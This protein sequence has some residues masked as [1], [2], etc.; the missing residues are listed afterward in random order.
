MS[1]I[2]NFRSSP[3]LSQPSHSSP[4]N[5]LQSPLPHRSSSHPRLSHS[6]LTSLFSLLPHKRASTILPPRPTPHFTTHPQVPILS[7]SLRQR[8]NLWTSLA[9]NLLLRKHCPTSR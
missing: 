5:P 2:P 8:F 3:L 9:Q 7:S 4:T 1:H 6:L